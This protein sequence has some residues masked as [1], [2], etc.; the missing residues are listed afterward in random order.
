MKRI[1]FLA[2]VLGPFIAIFAPIALAQTGSIS[3]IITDPSGAVVPKAEVTATSPHT[4]FKRTLLANDAGFYVFNQLPVGAYVISASMPGFKTSSS[5]EMDLHVADQRTV[6]IVLPLEAAAQSVTVTSGAA[7]VNLRS[8]EVSSLVSAEQVSELPLNGRNFTQLTLLVPGASPP[9]GMRPSATG[10]LAV[11]NISISMSGSVANSNLWLVD[12]VDNMDHGAGWSLLVF[13]S[14][15]AVEEFKVQ[16]NSYGAENAGGSGAQIT[17]VTKSG[18]NAFHGTAYEFLRND[19]LNANNFFLN[20]A[21][22]EKRPEL[23]Y[24]NFG[25]S[26]GGPIKKDKVFFFWS[27]EWRR[28]V[29]GVARSATVPTEAEHRGNFSGLHS[30]NLPTPVDPMT[31]ERFPGDTIPAARLSPAGQA[32]MKLLPPPTSGAAVNNWVTALPTGIPTRQ[33]QIRVDSSLSANT[34]LMFRYTQ[35][36]WRNPALNYGTAGGLW[37]DTGFPTVDSTWAQPSKS[38]AAR[39]THTFGPTAVNQFQF[40]YSNNRII[41]SEGV[42]EDISR[43]IIAAVPAVFGDPP[44]THFS[45]IWVGAP[46]AGSTGP[47]WHLAPWDDAQDIW[48]WKDDFA[49]TS[50]NHNLKIGALYARYLKDQDMIWDTAPSFWGAAPGGAGMGGGWGDSRAPGNGHGGVT[51]NVVADLLLKDTWW[52]DGFEISNPS[53]S[54]VR[55]H[56][57]EVYFADTWRARPRLTVDYGVRWSLLPPSF[58]ADGKMGNWIPALWDSTVGNSAP[59]NG[60][61]FPENLVMKDQGIL[62]GKDNLRGVEVGK[63]LRKSGWKIVAPRL[64][65]AWDPRGSGKWAVRAGAGMFYGRADMG[66]VGEMS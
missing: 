42:G 26:L 3:G 44:K 55:W 36:S 57:V 24:N 14:V 21:G 56:D 23:R 16:R 6:N 5:R 8:G 11:G 2:T 32:Y 7:E 37:G 53:R 17:V 54:K 35:E 62:G 49:K 66:P 1:G 33:E 59:L 61:I 64:G 19:L 40:G 25:Y 52:A 39:L 46:L 30:A 51:D 13:P 60:M 63:A 10:I 65:I 15:D 18:T 48:S 50:G 41:A 38:L 34:Q 28:E 31:G 22:I 43:A 20:R 4:G 29:R 47:L 58:D 9:D 27:E 45:G 12:G